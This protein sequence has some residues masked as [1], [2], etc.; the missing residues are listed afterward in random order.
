LLNKRDRRCYEY[1]SKAKAD[2]NKKVMELFRK[3]KRGIISAV[4]CLNRGVNVPDCDM[5]IINS[6]TST[7]AD[8]IQRLGRAVRLAEQQDKIAICFQ[9]YIK[10]TQDFY[11][12]LNR[13]KDVPI[14]KV[15]EGN[16]VLEKVYGNTTTTKK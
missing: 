9:I 12:T 8:F 13:T 15:F 7:K 10:D 14:T 2:E 4:N 11:W 3:S 6:G 16:Y 5:I 1:N